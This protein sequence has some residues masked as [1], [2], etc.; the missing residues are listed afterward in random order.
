MGGRNLRGRDHAAVLLLL[1][2]GFLAGIGWLVGAYLLWTS[3]SW[4]SRDK[5]IGTFVWP[6]GLSLSLFLLGLPTQTCAS[7]GNGHTVCTG[8]S[9]SPWLAAIVAAMVL[10]GPILTHFYLVR[11]AERP[12]VPAH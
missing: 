5:L 4:T 11:R 3:T 9:L 6:G 1:L 2:G 8:T 7:S 10:V 12:L